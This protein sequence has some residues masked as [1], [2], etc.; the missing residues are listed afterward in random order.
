V[1]EIVGAW[2]VEQEKLVLRR[3]PRGVPRLVAL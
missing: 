2:T 3:D 1:A